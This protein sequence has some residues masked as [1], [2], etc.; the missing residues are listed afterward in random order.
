MPGWH[1]TLAQRASVAL[2]AFFLITGVIGL[3][4]NPDFGTGANMSAELFL[5]D[6]NGWHAVAT[7]LLG[8]TAFVAAARPVW[9]T[10]FL[11]YSVVVNLTTAVLALFD[12]TPL[13]ILDLPNVA[14][15]VAL[16]V[17][18]SAVSAAVLLIQLRRDRG[19]SPRAAVG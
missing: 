13:G 1:G 16:H 11:A 6:W 18:V 12:K 8:A 4:I 17:L 15:D 5:V 19:P 14:T 2:G 10:G 9:A 3:I 7:L